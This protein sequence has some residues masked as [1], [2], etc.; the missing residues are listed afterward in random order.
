MAKSQIDWLNNGKNRG[1][2]WPLTSGCDKIAVGCENCWACRLAAT[3]LSHHPRYAGLVIEAPLAG[4]S[5]EERV[6]DFCGPIRYEWTGEVRLHPELLDM[7]LHWRKPR[8]IFVCPMSDLFHEAISP[9]FLTHVFDVIGRCPQHTFIVLTKRPKLM[10]QFLAEA[11]DRGNGHTWRYF[12]PGHFYPNVWLGVSVS[13]Q[14]EL[15]KNIHYLLETP[16][17][18][19]FLSIEPMLE[20]MNLSEYLTPLFYANLPKDERQKAYDEHWA[21]KHRMTHLSW[22]ILGCE[23]GPNRRPFEFAWARSVRD[24]CVAAG[25]PFYLKQMPKND[26]GKII[27]KPFLDG[28]QHL[29]FPGGA[30]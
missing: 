15:D 28:R 20:G 23:S 12:A 11:Y 3:R 21:G 14:T 19:R 7:P 10:H 5:L 17:A 27:H 6:K 4:E 30:R 8:R 16:A 9:G 18:V 24:Q 29:E 1:K 25:V 22:V 2:T 26:T 13:T